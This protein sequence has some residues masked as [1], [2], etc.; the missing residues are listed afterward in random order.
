MHELS[1]IFDKK[2]DVLSTNICKVP[3]VTDVTVVCAT[4]AETVSDDTLV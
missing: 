1:I 2:A 4:D 3:R